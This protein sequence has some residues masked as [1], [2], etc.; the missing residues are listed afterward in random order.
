[1]TIRGVLV[2]P[3]RY[4]AVAVV[5]RGERFGAL[6]IV[7]VRIGGAWRVADAARPEDGAPARP[8]PAAQGEGDVSPTE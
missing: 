5:R 6:V 2:A 1:M 8:L 7:L 4:E 3:H